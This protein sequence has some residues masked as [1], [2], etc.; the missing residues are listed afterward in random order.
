ML[1]FSSEHNRQKSRPSWS[2]TFTWRRT[3]NKQICQVAINAKKNKT[4]SAISSVSRRGV[5]S[6]K[7][8]LSERVMLSRAMKEVRELVLW[9]AGVRARRQ[10]WEQSLVVGV[11]W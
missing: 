11:C 10:R 5:I 6:D 8:G 7:G 1:G 3:D 4:A 9:I 2:L